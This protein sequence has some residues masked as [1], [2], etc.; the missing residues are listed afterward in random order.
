M[1]SRSVS[2]VVL[3]GRVD[4]PAPPARLVADWER[5]ISLP[6]AIFS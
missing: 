6:F 5:E 2:D 1:R 4:V 3:S